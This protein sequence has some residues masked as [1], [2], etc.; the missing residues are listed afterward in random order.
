MT[1]T[2][3]SPGAMAGDFR[4]GAV[5]GSGFA[6]FREHWVHFTA[7]GTVLF[8]PPLAIIVLFGGSAMLALMVG[9][10]GAD[11]VDDSEMSIAGGVAAIVYLVL[12]FML[13]AAA[14][15]SAFDT[16]RDRQPTIVRSVSRGFARFLPVLG[17]TLVI[18]LIMALVMGIGGGA[19]VGL[20]TAGGWVGGVLAAIVG[21]AAFAFLIWVYVRYSIAVPALVIERPG[22]FGS[23]RRSAALTRG[24]RWKML[25]IFLL[26]WIIFVIATS[27]LPLILLQLMTLSALPPGLVSVVSL[28]IRFFLQVVASVLFALFLCVAYYHL[29]RAK[30]G[31]G[32]EDI[33]AVFD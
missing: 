13:M 23:L 28:L 32:L 7:L 4:I 19:A 33:A 2:T 27:V 17:V 15:F 31:I 9:A 21:L 16:L 10:A 30:E 5:I 3:D 18:G 25:G 26:V 8:I 11:A 22:V 29:R 1:A 20:A 12:Y 24:Q 14:T 6:L